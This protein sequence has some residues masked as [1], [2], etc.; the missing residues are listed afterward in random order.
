MSYN[1]ICFKVPCQGGSIEETRE[2]CSVFNPCGEGA[3]DCDEDDECAGDL[4][5]GKNNCGDKF[6]W[7]SADCCEKKDD[8]EEQPKKV[9]GMRL[10]TFVQT[11]NFDYGDY[12]F[13]INMI[14]NF[15]IFHSFRGT[16]LL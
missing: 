16:T 6:T 9:P 15:I 5:C 8:D 4:V 1:S 2:C 11:Q 10:I 12:Y 13:E 7:A 3:G 14:I